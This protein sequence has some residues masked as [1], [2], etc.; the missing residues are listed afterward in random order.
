MSGPGEQGEDQREGQR[1]GHGHGRDDG[2]DDDVS[3]LL[4]G[5]LPPSYARE[6]EVLEDGAC[7][8][9]DETR[10]R[11]RLVVVRRGRVLLRGRCGAQVT[12]GTGDVLWLAGLRLLTLT[13][14][15]PGRT[16]LV[17][18]TRRR[19]SHPQASVLVHLL[20]PPSAL[21]PPHPG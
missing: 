18:L 3:P 17:S 21:D 15:G 12:C 19:L 5:R 16:E 2:W 7:V 8:P 20:S 4:S 1:A 9:F 13:N 14:P 11:D 10:W 6:V